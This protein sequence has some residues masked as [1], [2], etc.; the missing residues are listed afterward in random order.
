MLRKHYTLDSA[1]RYGLKGVRFPFIVAQEVADGA[2]TYVDPEGNVVTVTR[3]FLTFKNVTTY[4]QSMDVHENCHELVI[5]HSHG[6]NDMT[7]CIGRLV[8]DF[9]IGGKKPSDLPS[10]FSSSLESLVLG[11]L[12]D[13]YTGVDTD[14]VFFVW[15]DCDNPK[16][17]SMHLVVKGVVFSSDWVSQLKL[18]YYQM[19]KRIR[20][21]EGNEWDWIPDGGKSKPENLI[22]LQLARKSASLRMPLN[23]KIGG[24]PLKFREPDRFSFLDGLICLYDRQDIKN[25]QRIY[26]DQSKEDLLSYTLAHKKQ[27]VQTT[28]NKLEEIEKR[29]GCGENDDNVPYPLTLTDKEDRD[30]EDEIPKHP[31]Y[32]LTQED[33]IDAYELFHRYNDPNNAFSMGGCIGPFIELVRRKPSNCIISCKDHESLDAYLYIHPK[34]RDVYFACRKVACTVNGKK[35]KLIS[36][37]KQ[38]IHFI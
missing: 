33:Y 24:N 37:H 4:I 3:R 20:E 15:L 34:S 36:S 38:K 35:F 9:D 25:E 21:S 7:P 14:K 29:W 17:I 13:L 2:E 30:R 32:K 11:I 5:P 6:N 16:K 22:D 10:Y 28:A 8:F 18:F 27:L 23:S 1:T 31:K 19:A 26:D 12:I